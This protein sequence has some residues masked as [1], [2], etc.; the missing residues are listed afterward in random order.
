MSHPNPSLRA[1]THTHTH[2]YTP[3]RG[4]WTCMLYE[5]ERRG[6]MFSSCH[7]SSCRANKCPEHSQTSSPTTLSRPSITVRSPLYWVSLIK[8]QV[9]SGIV[10]RLCD[11]WHLCAFGDKSIFYCS[12]SPSSHTFKKK[13]NSLPVNSHSSVISDPS[14]HANSCLLSTLSNTVSPGEGQPHH[15]LLIFPL[16]STHIWQS[17]KLH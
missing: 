6:E 11:L 17:K 5:L 4:H 15:F 12:F 3:S 8:T 10:T 2:T 9:Q 16:K 7:S 1:H 14:P 13:K